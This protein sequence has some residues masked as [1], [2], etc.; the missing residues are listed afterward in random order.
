MVYDWL[1]KIINIAKT[2]ASLFDYFFSRYFICFQQKMTRIGS[3]SEDSGD[4]FFETDPKDK[5]NDTF[6]IRTH[7]DIYNENENDENHPSILV[8]ETPTK[9]SNRSPS[10]PFCHTQQDPASPES[11]FRRNVKHSEQV[12]FINTSHI[13]LQQIE[14]VQ[15]QL[16]G[17]HECID[18]AMT[19]YQHYVLEDLE[20]SFQSRYGFAFD[21]LKKLNTL[22]INDLTEI[23]TNIELLSCHK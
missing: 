20:M 16:N 6:I 18:S 9:Q 14:N 13:L 8:N 17:I 22:C 1:R 15:R 19:C 21:I 7:P 23:E 2:N 5:S 11:I 3:Q 4:E 12:Q 10:S